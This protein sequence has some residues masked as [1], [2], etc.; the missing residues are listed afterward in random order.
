MG[1]S[2]KSS[3]PTQGKS[4]SKRRIRNSATGV[5]RIP[6]PGVE[7]ELQARAEGFRLVIG[8]DEA[9][10]G[11]LAGPVVAA[12][13]AFSDEPFSFSERIA[14]SKQ[15]SAAQRERAFHEILKK[16]RVG[17]GV[18]S[19]AVVDS[20]NILNATHH[21]MTVAVEDLLGRLPGKVRADKNFSGSVQLLIDGNSFR[22]ELPFARRLIVK[23]D[24]RC[25][26]IACASIVAKVVRDGILKT[27]DRIY[28]QWG[29]GRHKGY[30]TAAHKKAIAQFGLTPIHRRTFNHV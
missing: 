9:G 10:R 12:A 3:S 2:Q 29:F 14:D 22:S 17:V 15:I 4:K 24:Q 21:A 7:F 1:R 23:G 27:Y 26:S 19:E 28:P 25:L 6:A 11:P 18:I 20:L 30:P 8:I 5:G 16:A 13:V